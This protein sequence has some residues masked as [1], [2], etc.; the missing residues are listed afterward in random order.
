MDKFRL[1][2]KTKKQYRKDNKFFSINY[3]Q[4]NY[5]WFYDKQKVCILA[6][7]VI[8]MYPKIATKEQMLN[9]YLENYPNDKRAH[10]ICRELK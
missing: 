5:N 7:R 9:W 1:P 3:D 2:R 6:M 10:Q 8:L 4:C